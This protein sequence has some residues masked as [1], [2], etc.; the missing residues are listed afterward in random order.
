LGRVPHPHH[1]VARAERR[2]GG[3]D[4]LTV[5]VETLAH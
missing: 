2:W 3:A 5:A 1:Y 4:V